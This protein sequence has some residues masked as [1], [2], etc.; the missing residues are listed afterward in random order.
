MRERERGDCK[1]IA[2]LEML[3][4]PRSGGRSPSASGARG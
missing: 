2:W 1:N 4:L 3:H